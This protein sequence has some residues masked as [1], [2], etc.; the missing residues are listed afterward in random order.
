M[1]R[2]KHR[3]DCQCPSCDPE[4][5][6]IMMMNPQQYAGWL[7]LTQSRLRAAGAAP[8]FRTTGGSEERRDHT[9]PDPWDIAGLQA[10]NRAPAVIAHSNEE[11]RDEHE[12]PDSWDIKGLQAAYRE[13]YRAGAR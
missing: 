2:Y 7:D 5:A 11:P 13:K 12:P 4:M 6:A 1:K 3:P 8:V 9:P 10:A